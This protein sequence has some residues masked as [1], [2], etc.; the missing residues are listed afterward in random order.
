MTLNICFP[1]S[2]SSLPLD[3]L[4]ALLPPTV[5]LIPAEDAPPP[6]CDIL[7]HGFPSG[8]GWKAARRCVR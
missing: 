5:A 6:D 2:A 3:K 4:A 8:H 7:V 1:K